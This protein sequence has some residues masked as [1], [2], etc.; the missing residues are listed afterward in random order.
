MIDFAIHYIEHYRLFLQRNGG[1]LKKSFD[2]IFEG[3][4]QAIWR[5]ILVIAI[6]FIPLLF[7]A[8]VPYITVGSFFFVIM[9]VGGITTL[10]LIPALVKVFGLVR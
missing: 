9:F 7:S 10:M 4:A 6:G 5:N 1:D 2:Q 3:T 8:L